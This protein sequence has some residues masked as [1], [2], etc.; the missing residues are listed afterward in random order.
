MTS[1]WDMFY[2][3]LFL[4]PISDHLFYKI[5]YLKQKSK[6]EKNYTLPSLEYLLELYELSLP[7]DDNFEFYYTLL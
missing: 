4:L 2:K 7:N 5:H 3:Q 6:F 1:S